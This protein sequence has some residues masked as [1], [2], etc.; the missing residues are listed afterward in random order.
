MNIHWLP[1]TAINIADE[2]RDIAIPKIREE[3]LRNAHI[4]MV[5]KPPRGDWDEICRNP[6]SEILPKNYEKI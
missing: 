1:E 4:Q 3:S 2:T 6:Y 5:P